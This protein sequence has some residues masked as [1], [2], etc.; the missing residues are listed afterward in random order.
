[1]F[2]C[3]TAMIILMSVRRVLCFNNDVL[4]CTKPDVIQYNNLLPDKVSGITFA[5]LFPVPRL[6]RE[7]QNKCRAV[8]RLKSHTAVENF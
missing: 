5:S 1:M 3:F 4:A 6:Y 2:N 7:A 8:C